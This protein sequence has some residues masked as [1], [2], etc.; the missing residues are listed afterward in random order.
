M[1]RCEIKPPALIVFV[2]APADS[3]CDPLKQIGG[4]LAVLSGQFVDGGVGVLLATVLSQM[5]AYSSQ[6]SLGFFARFMATIGGLAML[7]V[8]SSNQQVRP[9]VTNQDQ[10]FIPNAMMY[11]FHMHQVT[12]GGNAKRR[13]QVCPIQKPLTSFLYNTH[14][15]FP[16]AGQ[17]L[18]PA[19]RPPSSRV[20]VH[21]P[22][23]SGHV[24]PQNG[25]YVCR[26][27]PQYTTACL[28]FGPAQYAAI[29]GF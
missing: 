29:L 13:E 23:A 2:F 17:A 19:G 3:R 12:Q 1:A 15:H 4:S 10:T 14:Q 11:A 18:H 28:H 7:C 8:D 24:L 22:V 20:H 9:P 21:Y 27:L 26:T 25:L 5:L 6:W 16:H